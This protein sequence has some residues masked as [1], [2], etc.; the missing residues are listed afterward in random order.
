M[1]EE[2]ATK[3]LVNVELGVTID[4]EIVLFHTKFGDECDRL[5]VDVTHDVIGCVV[6][7]LTVDDKNS[8]SAVFTVER[9]DQ[10]DFFIVS[11]TKV[12]RNLVKMV[13]EDVS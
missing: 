5:V 11:V 9:N 3:Q 6:K 2:K 8:G 10:E 1:N 13:L 4:N 12:D 7:L